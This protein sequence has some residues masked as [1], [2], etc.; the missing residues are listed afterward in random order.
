MPEMGVGVIIQARMGSSRLPGKSLMRL[1]SKTLIDHVIQR[2]LASVT[3]NQVY[4]AT[5]NQ[6]EDKVLVEHVAEKYGIKIFLG[7]R[8]DVRSRFAAISKDHSLSKVVRITADDPFKDPAHIQES[9]RQLDL[10]GIDYYNNFETPVFPIGLDVESFRTK[11][12]YDNI[13][14]DASSESMEHV[15]LGLRNS[16]NLVKKFHQG[17][18]EFTEIRLTI[19]TLSDLEFCNRLLEVNPEMENTAFD[20]PTTR[21]ALI[22]LGNY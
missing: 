12:L 22:A 10:G 5:T 21:A 15:T 17:N 14:L 7:D 8:S 4:L 3:L 18:P 19:D 1:G 6:Q 13:R 20:W 9:I 11:A 2:C 16:P